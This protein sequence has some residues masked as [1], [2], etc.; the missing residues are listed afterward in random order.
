MQIQEKPP[1]FFNTLAIAS[2]MFRNQPRRNETL[3][4]LYFRDI[5]T[6][7]RQENR[8]YILR[9]K[10]SRFHLLLI[11]YKKSAKKCI[12]RD[13]S[14]CPDGVQIIQIRDK[15]T[16]QI[17]RKM[18]KKLDSDEPVFGKQ[19]DM[20]RKLKKFTENENITLRCIRRLATNHFYKNKW[21][22]KNNMTVKEF[23][24]TWGIQKIHH[25]ILVLVLRQS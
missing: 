21:E 5:E 20:L 8:N 3:E 2:L 10:K 14:Y 9:D 11:Y 22:N 25:K 18:V 4:N 12:M 17:L 16:T 19:I 7:F 6:V 1:T 13:F 23:C 15:I 24:L